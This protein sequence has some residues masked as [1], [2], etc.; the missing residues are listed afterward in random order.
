VDK[1]AVHLYI[2][3]EGQRVLKKAPRPYSGVLPDALLELDP[4]TLKR[5]QR[6]LDE[7]L[8]ILSPDEDG[9]YKP[10]GQTQR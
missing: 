8:A 7:L 5:L 2:T 9:A 10:L 1:R 3:K 4:R 6:D